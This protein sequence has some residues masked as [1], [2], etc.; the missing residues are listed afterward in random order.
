MKILLVS[1]FLP[2]EKATHAG[3]R[4]VFE[5]LSQLATRHEVTLATRYEVG[6]EAQV[7]ELHPFCRK[8]HTCSYPA[9]SHRGPVEKARLVTSYLAFSRFADR[10]VRDGGF[11]LVQVEWV[12]TALLIRRHGVPMV[13]DAH[14]V[15]TKPAERRLT[16]AHGLGR[17]AAGVKYR[18]IRSAERR[19]VRR[20]DTVLTVSDFDRR[21][22]E[23]MEPAAR[24][25]TV[26]IPAG[27]DFAGRTS[28]V[29]QGTILFLA[30]YRNHRSNV[31]GAL[32][33]AREVF[34]RVKADFPEAR[35]ILAGYGPPPELLE[36]TQIDAAIEVPGFID[37]LEGCYREAAVFAAPILTGGGIIVK[38]LDA[39]AGGRPVVTTSFG[40][41]G[42]GATPGRDLVVEDDPSGFAAALVR[43]LR[44]Y[45][46]ALAL[47]E[48]GQRFVEANYSSQALLSGLNRVYG[49]VGRLRNP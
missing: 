47:G 22:L 17:L 5:I 46:E 14:D 27:L 1:L 38:I 2:G 26:P 18:L 21:Y 25:R 33:L 8:V 19:I 11:D 4:Y 16:G 10:L 31:D 35:L 15:I 40:N 12:E 23:K 24:I 43:I 42:I 6:Q 28:T 48:S 37:D 9:F 44:N 45:P 7:E 49:E 30:S 36:L 39:L 41:E 3:G 34:P 13:L 20:F 32:W 29:R